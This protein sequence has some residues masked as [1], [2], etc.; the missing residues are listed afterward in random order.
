MEAEKE[1]IAKAYE[2]E[3]IQIEETHQSTIDKLKT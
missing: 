3:I 1:A 2:Q